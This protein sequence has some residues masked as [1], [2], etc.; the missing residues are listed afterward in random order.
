MKHR[1][2]NR[3]YY[4]KVYIFKNTTNKTSTKLFLRSQQPQINTIMNRFLIFLLLQAA[5]FGLLQ[6]QPRRQ[7]I[8]ESTLPGKRGELNVRNAM[9]PRLLARQPHGV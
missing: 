8:D 4:L 6:A 9:Y 7:S 5:C 3:R 2:R 1:I